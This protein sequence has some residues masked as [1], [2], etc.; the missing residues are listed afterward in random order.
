V[1]GKDGREAGP[2]HVDLKPLKYFRIPVKIQSLKR[3]YSKL[4]SVGCLNAGTFQA[5]SRIPI[6]GAK[7]LAQFC[8]VS[9]LVK[10]SRTVGQARQHKSGQVTP[11][12]RNMAE[13]RIGD[14]KPSAPRHCVPTRR[15]AT[16]LADD[17]EVS[18][19]VTRLLDRHDGDQREARN[20]ALLAAE[21]FPASRQ[22]ME[23][24]AASILQQTE[25]VRDRHAADVSSGSETVAGLKLVPNVRAVETTRIAFDAVGQDLFKRRAIP[26][27]LSTLRP[28]NAQLLLHLAACPVK[29]CRLAL[30]PVRCVSAI[31]SPKISRATFCVSICRLP[32]GPHVRTG[33]LPL[34]GFGE[35][36]SEMNYDIAKEIF[37]SIS[38]SRCQDQWRDLID[39]ATIYARVRV[40]WLGTEQKERRLLGEERSAYHDALIASCQVMADAMTNAGEDTNWRQLLGNDRK[41]IGDF[42]CFVHCILGQIAG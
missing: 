25:G 35:K 11:A 28:R 32:S 27:A 10:R 7:V 18:D 42:A 24:V 29:R 4:A 15:P 31:S 13:L 20:E 33:N 1:V 12:R 36:E 23:H 37:K 9:H 30:L 21:D 8:R 41:G 34:I 5:I 39:K 14:L 40:D 16:S 19:L 2:L 38:G 6:K 26:S 3:R 22:L 17:T